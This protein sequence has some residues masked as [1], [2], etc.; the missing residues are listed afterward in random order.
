MRKKRK[1]KK[2]KMNDRKL[3]KEKKKKK[4]GRSLCLKSLR[5]YLSHCPRQQIQ[6]DSAQ[7]ME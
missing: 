1:T 2:K 3:K 6:A 4:K 7:A 5:Q